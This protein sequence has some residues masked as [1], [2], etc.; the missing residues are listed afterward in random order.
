VNRKKF[1]ELR[2]C[3]VDGQRPTAR[4]RWIAFHRLW[5]LAQGHGAWQDMAAVDCFRVIFTNWDGIRLLNSNEDTLSRVSTPSFLR[6]ELLKHDKRKRLG[7]PDT[8]QMQSIARQLHEQ[9]TEMTPDD[10]AEVR[11]KVIR[12]F[13]DHALRNDI[14]VPADDDAL[15]KWLANKT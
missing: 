2:M 6:R 3:R 4:E 1:D 8:E 12:K 10:V 11:Q 14:P 15:M 13:R 5:R 9:G 7:Y